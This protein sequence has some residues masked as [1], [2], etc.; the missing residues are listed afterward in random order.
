[1]T[2]YITLP[3]MG[4]LIGYSTNWLAIKMVF[5]PY[6]EKRV[7]GVRVP[8][9]PGVMA[10]E[11]YVFSKKLGDTLSDNVITDEELGK[12]FQNV[13]FNSIVTKAIEDINVDKTLS[14]FI[15]EEK[16]VQ[17][18]QDGIKGLIKTNINIEEKRKI[19]EA[20]VKAIK[21][22]FGRGEF[23]N[24]FT[25]EEQVAFVKGL[26]NND[27]IFKVVNNLITNLYRKVEVTDETIKDVLGEEIT[28]KI[29]NTVTSNSNKIRLALLEYINSEDFSFLEGKLFNLVEAGLSK[30]PMASMFGGNA[31]A[32][33]ITPIL[34]ENAV[35]Y[36]EDEDNNEEIEEVVKNFIETFLK[37]DNKKV[38]EF[39]SQD[40]IFMSTQKIIVET[41]N[42]LV[43]VIEQGYSTIDY[44]NIVK[45]LTVT[46]ES[47][48]EDLI[49]STIGSFVNNEE[50]LNAV[51]KTICD[52]L[53]K[54]KVSKIINVENE[55]T[56]QILGGFL[57][58]VVDK[59]LG[60]LLNQINIS[61][62]VEDK[63]NTFEMEQAEKLVIGVMN[64]ELKML[65]NLGGVL[66]FVIGCISIFL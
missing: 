36:L 61:K 9:T 41:C 55:N 12:H 54:V 26:K 51:A 28:S 15:Q 52:N 32:K 58:N 14:A 7:F 10:K 48:V 40:I 31:L 5:R 63:I 23:S 25:K 49:Y 16:Q 27:E 50:Q 38:M 53:L 33:M 8:F 44:Q 57:K 4:A 22:N 21:T 65:T 47:K 2:E 3:I 43:E 66:G 29:L 59:N 45:D 1:M 30:V 17:V 18:L 11:R 24:V 34:I 19:V 64:K 46:L 37:T 62:I 20:V 35:E 42:S 13:D 39:L 60:V 6:E 56:I